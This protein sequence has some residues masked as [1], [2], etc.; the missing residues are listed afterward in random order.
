MGLR[1]K[2]IL[3]LPRIVNG[4][5]IVVSAASSLIVAP[6][7]GSRL[8]SHLRMRLSGSFRDQSVTKTRLEKNICE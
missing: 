5:S 3:E 8:D 2:V 1:G 6:M 7:V 4:W